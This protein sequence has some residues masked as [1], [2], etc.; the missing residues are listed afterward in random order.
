M[1]RRLPAL[2][3]SVRLN[4]E[5]DRKRLP[6]ILHHIAGKIEEGN[7]ILG[8]PYPIRDG[9]S[10][11]IGTWLCGYSSEDEPTEMEKRLEKNLM[12]KIDQRITGL[13]LDIETMLG[14]NPLQ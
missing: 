4:N 7:A 5:V 9:N 13:T 2:C 1:A 3:L 11:V 10:D 14:G 8:G 6:H 12:E